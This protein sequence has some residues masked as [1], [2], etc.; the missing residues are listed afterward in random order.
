[1]IG[2][3]MYTLGNGKEI[4]PGMIIQWHSINDIPSTPFIVMH[5]DPQNK[6]FAQIFGKYADGEE[7]RYSWAYT[8]DGRE[9]HGYF[10]EANHE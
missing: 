2:V 9:G 8:M 3:K 6:D 4:K 5:I 1:M 10:E 7:C